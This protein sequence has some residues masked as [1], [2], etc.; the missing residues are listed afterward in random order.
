MIEFIDLEWRT[1]WF[2]IEN[3][4]LKLNLNERETNLNKVSKFNWN[5]STFWRNLNYSHLELNLES[6]FRLNFSLLVDP[7]KVCLVRFWATCAI[8]PKH[9]SHPML[10][11]LNLQ[12]TLSLDKLHLNFRLSNHR[13]NA[14]SPFLY[15]PRREKF[16]AL[17]LA[18]S[19]FKRFHCSNE[20][21]SSEKFV[22]KLFIAALLDVSLARPLH[23]YGDS[24][25]N[26]NIILPLSMLERQT[27]GTGERRKSKRKVP[28]IP[29]E[30]E[31]YSGSHIEALR[32]VSEEQR[33]QRF[34][35]SSSA[36][37]IMKFNSG[38]S[39]RIPS[40]IQRTGWN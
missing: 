39:V 9:S 27:K 40:H 4:R 30:R 13:Q 17:K 10:P 29:P 14:L 33:A 3:E 25:I 35:V 34:A 15:L 22:Y 26:I 31:A 18:A 38:R 11:Q 23:M 37:K 20:N 19:S 24:C 1:R 21:I 6:T 32:I 12:Q 36:M 28:T 16:K 2:A 5:S 8:I 7:A